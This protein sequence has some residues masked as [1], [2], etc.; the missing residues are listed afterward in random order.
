MSCVEISL[1]DSRLLQLDTES[2][3][4]ATCLSEWLEQ[5]GV[6]LNTRCAGAGLCRGCRVFLTG[7]E[8]D[9]EPRRSCKLTVGELADV[10]TASA[11]M[12]P[13][14]SIRDG[15]I[16]GVSSFEIRCNDSQHV[17]RNGYGL[18]VDLGTTTVA[19]ALW[20]L[21][22]GRCI[23][24]ETQPNGQRSFGDNVV[25]RIQFGTSS[26]DAVKRLQNAVVAG[27]LMPLMDKLCGTAGIQST[28][29]SEVVVCGNTVMLHTLAGVPLDGLATFPFKPVFLASQAWESRSLGFSKP[30]TVRSP[31]CPGPFVGADITA[32]ARAC[33]LFAGQGTALLIDFGT[34]GELLLKRGE[35]F[36]ATATAAG[37]AFE[38]GRLNCGATAGP[39]VISHVKLHAEHW[40]WRVD[41]NSEVPPHGLSGSAYVDAIAE[42]L[43][44]GALDANGRLNINHHLVES[45]HLDGVESRIL[46]IT[47]EVFISESDVAEIIQAKAAIIGG[48]ATLLDLAEVSL[49]SLDAVYIAGGFGFHLDLANA[50]A[51]GLLPC[52]APAR[53]V[54]VGNSSLAGASLFLLAADT[55]DTVT[56]AKSIEVIELN[57]CETFEDHYVDAMTL[58]GMF[59]G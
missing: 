55:D 38:G 12:I 37:P 28:D 33:G 42:A 15:G 34:N 46:R 22:S 5:R 16:H 53:F 29:V 3:D 13:P 40:S 2:E 27:T 44:D 32:G 24:T 50:V 4:S 8:R 23:S 6:L 36:F 11:I 14:E 59:H 57:A 54:V 17:A 19:A 25:S 1:P 43:F 9:R 52:I 26:Q 47:P 41:N 35:R 48:V 56:Q 18:A 39:G 58:A 21:A 10:A 45:L 51:I 7:G 49:D 30:F 20:D 31:R